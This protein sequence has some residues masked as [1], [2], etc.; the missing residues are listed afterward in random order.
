M[1]A[2][3]G[4]V[5][6][7]YLI[8]GVAGH[9]GMGTVYAARHPR[10]PR[11]V[12][13]K[14][15]NRE[16]S[17]DPELRRRFEQ[18]ANVIARL[19]HPGIVGIH[20][21]GSD[22]GHLWI[23]MQYIQGIDASR[24]DPRT[25]TVERAVRLIGETAAALDYA[26]SRGVL[27]RDIKPANILLSASEAGRAERA[28]LTDFGIARLV[29]SN[30]H[31]TS[32]GTFTA[33]LAYASPEQL[34]G[35]RVD[36]RS[37]QYSLA[38]T[39]YTM[40]A[41]RSPFAATNPGQV[42]AGHLN[43]PVPPLARPDVSPQLKGA[44][45]RAMAKQPGERFGDCREFAQ[46]LTLGHPGRPG[47]GPG[48]LAP[49]MMNPQR[50]APRQQRPTAE[51]RPATAPARD[52]VP[53]REPVPTRELGH[54]RDQAADPAVVPPAD[55]GEGRVSAA[56]VGL[57]VATVALLSGLVAV[58]RAIYWGADL[59]PQVSDLQ[60]SSYERFYVRRDMEQLL[61]FVPTAVFLCFG[62]L[63][64]FFRRRAGRTLVVIGSVVA[65]LFSAYDLLNGRFLDEGKAAYG[66]SLAVAIALLIGAVSRPTARWVNGRRR[67]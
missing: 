29:D 17:A 25:L 4:T 5:F 33:T 51:P 59:M 61:G 19:D 54:G 65:V 6:A 45:Q 53:T 60:V 44:I 14:L 11:L 50:T 40:L 41:G 67:R 34:S 32:T 12:A 46:A 35:E 55:R 47:T 38:C 7:G 26:H 23:A 39:L 22:A 24:I 66:V 52:K 48:R 16:V 62:A 21:R 49:T 8:E 10:L 15:L 43:K 30:T 56:I 1:D 13:L 31:L 9:G 64:L 57:I 37:D 36:H 27:H 58:W 20:D 18:E 2:L 42:V 3:V 63:M 28:V